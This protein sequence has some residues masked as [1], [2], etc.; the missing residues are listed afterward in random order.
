MRGSVTVPVT[1]NN[2]TTTQ[3]FSIIEDCD[4]QAILG[5]DFMQKNKILLDM[6]TSEIIHKHESH[7]K[8]KITINS[9]YKNF[10][11]ENHHTKIKCSLTTE[12][13]SFLHPGSNVL[14]TRTELMPGV[15]LEES[16]T[17][18]LRKNVIFVVI[19]N[20]NPY[21]VCV[22]PSMLL[23]HVSDTNFKM[24]IP[25]DEA[26]IASFGNTN[27]SGPIPPLSQEKAEYLK[28]N[29]NCPAEPDIRTK[30][31][32]LILLNH[33]CFAQDKFDLGFSDI[34][35]HHINMKNKQP[36]YTK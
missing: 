10:I 32:Q 29:L 34:V 19:T 20:T 33:D 28:Q 1:V 8:A 36:I 2:K 31:E 4:N 3:N 24:F 6:E 18:V 16:L 12:D 14:T 35:T 15:F 9:I 22:K 23:G 11:P 5:S 25:V 26:K 7:A 21:L 13:G 27:N 30:Y 17:K